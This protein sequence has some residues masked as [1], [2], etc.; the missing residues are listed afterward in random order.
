MGLKGSPPY[1]QQIMATEVLVGLEGEICEIYLD[2]VIVFAESAAMLLDR[3]RLV[4]DRFR[5]KNMTLSPSKCILFVNSVEYCGHL[6]DKDGIHFEQSKIDG[7]LNFKTPQ[8]Q[9]QLRSF[10]GLA[11]WFR[12]HVANHSRLA[13][14]LHGMMTGY[15]KNKKLEWT[16]DLLGCYENLKKAVHECPKLFF[17][18]E[19]HPIVLH[20]DASQYGMGAYLFQ[21]K[22][23]K[24]VPIRF[25]SKAFDDRMARWSTIQQEGYAIYHAITE[26][27]YLLRDRKFT[28]RTDHANLRLLHAESDDKVIRWM[29]TLQCYDFEIEHIKGTDNTVADGL[30]RMCPDDSLIVRKRDRQSHSIKA[31]GREME[32]NEEESVDVLVFESIDFVDSLS[33]SKI[34]IAQQREEFEYMELVDFWALAPPVLEDQLIVQSISIVHNDV[35]G[36]WGVNRTLDLLKSTPAMVKAI[37]DDRKILRGLRSQCRRFIMECPTCQK[38]S[39]LKL[40]NKAKAFTVSEFFPMHTLMIDYIEGLPQ[41]EQGNSH[42]VVIID[43]FSRFCTLH[44]T[45]TTKAEE[46]SRVLLSHWGIFGSPCRLVSDKGP[47]L[48][49][50]LIEDFIALVGTEHIKTLTASKEE[51]AIVERLNREVMRHLRNLVFDRQVYGSWS[52]YIP[53][54]QRKLLSTIHSSTGLAP[55]EIIFGSAISLERGIISPLLD[56]E[57]EAIQCTSTYQDWVRNLIATQDLLI[58]KARDNLRQK[59]AKHLEK[60]KADMEEV[61]AQPLFPINSYVLAEPLGYFTT[62]K[63]PNKLKPMLKGPFKVVAISDDNSTYNVLKLVS[64]RI[65]KYH[66][67]SLRAFHSRP[68]DVD[69]TKY[70]IRDQNFF[71]VRSVKNFKPKNFNKETS[72][73][74]L[75]F[76]IEWD[77]DGSETWE[78][79]SNVRTLREVS[80]WVQSKQCKNSALK[81]LFPVND[82][83]EQEESDDENEREEEENPSWPDPNAQLK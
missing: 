55:A 39:F 69:P 60:R 53:F 26:W 5:E 8:T 27:D 78:P 46:L 71:M 72:C 23:G 11:N 57:R 77:I 62:R 38:H 31:E 41:D 68:G 75:E 34:L 36:H 3:L 43:C 28:V 81:Q 37:Q 58:A 4:F 47:A 16:P 20:T 24:E 80:K 21:I 30:S 59:D 70:A 52:R 61:L 15:S 54:I 65:R 73:K 40:Q 42:I 14:P 7:V 22:D 83:E 45:K 1:F 67:K 64:M 74:A 76:L 10:L 29:I 44:P 9:Q 19:I 48:N 49:S 32:T 12:D 6:L 63:E 33:I 66:V 79:W 13:K 18:D 2:D 82:R 17:M 25:M 56:E 35:S 51:N 50:H